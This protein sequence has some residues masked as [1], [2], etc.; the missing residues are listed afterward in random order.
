MIK[1]YF[2][3]KNERLSEILPAVPHLMIV[4]LPYINL[5]NLSWLI[6]CLFFEEYGA[7]KLMLGRIF[8]ADN[9]NAII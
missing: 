7:F 5:L 4:L 1:K 2:H 6:K 8:S 9:Y 3:F